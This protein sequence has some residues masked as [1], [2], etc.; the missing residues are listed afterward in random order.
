MLEI[1]FALAFIFNVKIKFYLEKSALFVCVPRMIDENSA[2]DG[3]QSPNAEPFRRIEIVIF[4]MKSLR[5][6]ICMANGQ[7]QMLIR[8][9]N[10]ESLETL[11][12]F[13]NE[14]NK[15]EGEK[16]ARH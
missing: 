15:R 13:R 14:T 2:N 7:I 6:S 3:K 11:S 16:K 5:T 10:F 9:F 12:N 8:P 4:A 1:Y